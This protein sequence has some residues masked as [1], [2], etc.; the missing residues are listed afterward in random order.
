MQL[1]GGLFLDRT[2]RSF[3]RKIQETLLAIQ[4][5]RSYTKQQIFTMYVNQVYLA[6]GNYGM[7]AAS[8]YYFN[9]PVGKLTLSQAALLAG[10]IRGP[11]YSPLLN[12]QRALDRR[13]LVLSLMQQ[14]GK[15]TAQQAAAAQSRA[16]GPGSAGRPQRAGALLR[17][18]DPQVSRKH[19]R[20]RS[21]PRARPARLHHAQRPDAARRQSRRLSTACTPTSAATAGA[22]AC[23]TS[24][25]RPPPIWTPIRTP[26]GAPPSKKAI[27]STR[28]SSPPSDKSATL[29]SDATAPCSLPPIS[30][31]PAAPPTRLLK[32]GDIALVHVV[33]I[34]GDHR[35]GPHSSRTPA[36]RPPWWPLTTAP[37]KSKP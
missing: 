20:H 10:L 18:G 4:I 29:R 6:H 27:T 2:D 25:P 37:A 16:A 5:E 3:R 24:P 15:I 9:R 11:G 13:N 36:R 1:A 23:A 30:P 22:A 14:Q 12:P 8:Q 26:T 7:E 21:R 33:D 35:Q 32:P 17:R 19:L 34:S 28:W 31:G